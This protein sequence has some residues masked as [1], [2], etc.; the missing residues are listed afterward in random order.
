MKYAAVATRIFF[1]YFVVTSLLFSGNSF[2]TQAIKSLC[3][4]TLNYER[5]LAALD[6]FLPAPVFI[7]QVRIDVD[8]ALLCDWQALTQLYDY[9][10]ISAQ[11][12]KDAVFYLVQKNKFKTITVSLDQDKA[13]LLLNLETFWAFDRV[14]IKGIWVGKKKY[15]MLYTMQAGQQ[16]DESENK[17]YLRAIKKKLKNEGYC[18]AHVTAT[19][20]YDYSRKT[21]RVTVFIDKGKRCLNSVIK[22]IPST[23]RPFLFFGNKFFNGEQ[24]KEQLVLFGKDAWSLP[25]D[26]LAQEL[27]TYYYRHGFEHVKITTQE[28]EESCIFFI[29][30]GVQK[31]PTASFIFPIT[32]PEAFQETL[33][34][35]GKTIIQN[36]TTLA[37]HIIERELVYAQGQPFDQ[38]KIADSLENLKK[39]E[40][41]DALQLSP[42][43]CP[44]LAEKTMILSVHDDD[45]YELKLKGGISLQQMSK[46]FW[47]AGLSYVAGGSFLI[48]NPFNR[49]DQIQI[50]AD[51]TH[52]YH[53]FS[54]QY[55]YPWL[56]NIPLDSNWQ[57]YA[58][59]YLQPG[60]RHNQKN[61]YTFIQ[62]GAMVSLAYKP[63]LQGHIN[64]GIEWMETRIVDHANDPRLD[65]EITRALYFEPLLV[66]KK[67][68]YV[69]VEPTFIG[70]RIINPLNPTGGSFSLVTLKT[71]IPL[72]R[73]P[74]NSFFLKLY[75]EHSFYIP[76]QKTILALRARAGHI[77]YHHFKNIM[78]A[79]RFYLGGANSIRSYETDKC[80]P[81]GLIHNQIGHVLVPQGARSLFNINVELRIPVY[82]K[83][84][85]A[86]FQDIGALSNN[87]FADI[88]AGIVAG[89]GCGIRYQ[90][91][92]GPLRFDIAFKWSKPKHM[93]RYAWFLSFGNAF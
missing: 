36:N 90:T 62:Q 76:L 10:V 34:S 82:K 50:I 20:K 21:V 66:D 69:L 57:I 91:P 23:Q 37:D 65:R 72:Q 9:S 29:E 3:I 56:G 71:M 54:L 19:F 35:F 31:K 60:L 67:I 75:A 13:L 6:T 85:A 14:K 12:L 27:A 33:S 16:F 86:I 63:W 42:L 40:L 7:N 61:I 28:N 25:A 45:P 41:F 5:E 26:I 15:Q 30:E 17:Y 64:L 81:L 79:E 77:F 83:C 74:L 49:A 84:W 52:G 32:F 58:S 48:K 44:G 78:P 53:N 55:H 39:L 38:K 93:G 47:F 88:K 46:H 24:L 18:D 68:P 1:F 2:C 87:Y 11:M 4:T 51:Y 80:P 59:R 73:Q 43:V 8:C 89:T 92:I 22:G 70:D